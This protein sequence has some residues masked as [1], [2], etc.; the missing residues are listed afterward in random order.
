MPHHVGKAD[1]EDVVRRSG[2]AWTILQPCAYLQ[3]FLPAIAAD[4]I[5]VPYRT[6]APFGLVALADVGEAAATVILDDSHIG[7]TTY[8]LGGPAMV[9]VDEVA[10]AA[11]TVVGR[12]VTAERVDPGVWS[13][14]HGA[15]LDDH[16]RESLL[17]MFTYYDRY[18]LPTGWRPLAALL[19]R[20]PTSVAEALR[21]DLG[22][23][24]AVDT[25]HMGRTCR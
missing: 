6:D 24:G 12:P 16:V 14:E 3:N 9:T 13:S 17:V 7:A 23:R 1:A 20:T 22:D 8:E 11:A 25:A 19:R 4:A 2:T 18:G 15:D 5:R 21:R 10:A